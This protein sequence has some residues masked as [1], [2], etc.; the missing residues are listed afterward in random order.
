MIKPTIVNPTAEEKISWFK[1]FKERRYQIY[2]S[3]MGWGCGLIFFF[4]ALSTGVLFFWLYGSTSTELKVLPKYFP[5]SFP[6]WQA[7][8]YQKIVFYPGVKKDREVELWSWPGKIKNN[9]WPLN[10]F[11]WSKMIQDL[12]TP[13]ADQNLD[14]VQIF[15]QKNNCDLEKMLQE[16]Q[17]IL[18]NAGYQTNLS[19]A[20]GFNQGLNF[21]RGQISGNFFLE[22]TPGENKCQIKETIN[23]QH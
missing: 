15:W 22:Q 8:S 3:C 23:Y 6:L 20:F 11:N 17:K 4:L 14:T 19:E 5:P 1:R 12:K 16:Y 9:L 2:Q 7:S 10:N 13:V 21:N 18:T